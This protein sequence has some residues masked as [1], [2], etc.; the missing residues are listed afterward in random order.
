VRR[1]PLALLR[2]FLAV[3]LLSAAAH[4]QDAEA[5]GRQAVEAYRAKDYATAETLWKS[6]LSE[7]LTPEERARVCYNLGN[8]A[9]RDGRVTEAVAWYTMAVRVRPRDAGAWSNLE[10]AR[11]EAGL[12]PA[13]RGDLRATVLRLLGALDEGEAQWLLLGCLVLW[14]VALAGEA[15]RGGKLWTRLAWLGLG[16][17]L[18]GAAPLAHARLSAQTDPVMVVETPSVSLRA[19]PDLERPPRGQ[20]Q[21][22]TVVERIDELPDWVRI[23]SDVAGIG[24]V[25]A[26]AVFELGL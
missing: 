26:E 23:E 5:I 11:R 16:L 8:T 15:L 25:P 20:V 4:A 7:F 3:V 19:E 10:H 9:Y 1:I 12:E 24:W 2:A 14:G 21:A 22:G 18:V 17:V 13:D 6:L